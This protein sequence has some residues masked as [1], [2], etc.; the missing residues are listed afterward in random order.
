VDPAELDRRIDRIGAAADTARSGTR[1]EWREVWTDIKATGAAFKQVKFP[2]RTDREQAWQRFQAAIDNVKTEQTRQREQRER[3]AADSSGHLDHIR[4]LVS[5]AAPDD[6]L[7]RVVLGLCTGG[8][9]LIVETALDAVLGRSDEV[10]A[11][12]HR[13]SALLREAG[14]YLSANKNEM[15]GADKA[16]AFGAI[17]EGRQRLDSDWAQWKEAIREA[18]AARHQDYLERQARRE[19][20]DAK[21][22]A[23]RDNQNAYIARLE[24]A[25]ERLEGARD[26]RQAHLRDLEEKRAEAWSD[27]FRD[28][29]DGWISEEESNISDIE[30]KMRSVADKLEEAKGKLD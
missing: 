6:G 3:A 30:D 7:W 17:Q 16:T 11:D 15:R 2:D 23:W 10:Y 29:V 26:R 20:R 22:R 24:D 8:I 18:K 14:Q 9:S 12:L 5:D 1:V 28:R 19:E 21:R 4:A 13:R 27:G 25:L